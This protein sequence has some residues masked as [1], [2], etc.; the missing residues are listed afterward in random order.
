MDEVPLCLPELNIQGH[1]DGFIYS[2]TPIPKNWPKI[3]DLELLDDV[4]E[5]LQ[6]KPFKSIEILEIKS[7][8][9]GQF[10]S[11]TAPLEEHLDQATSYAA[12][13]EDRRKKL[14][15][16]YTG[17]EEFIA[18]EPDRHKEHLVRFRFATETNIPDWVKGKVF[19]GLLSDAILFNTQNPVDRSIFL[20]E[21]K[22]D[23]EIKEF[24]IKSDS[25]RLK[26]LREKCITINQTVEALNFLSKLSSNP[27]D[28]SK[29]KYLN[30]LPSLPEEAR[31]KSSKH[32]RWCDFKHICYK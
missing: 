16:R 4:Y 8:N 23:Q 2:Y 21:D 10:K 32:C 11:L 9:T 28:F 7:M 1:T 27:V 12:C 20:Y 19:K 26:V 17:W 22:N 24:V 6:N 13:A 18:S 3:L 31:G 25:Q 5:Y 14:H 15:Q 30:L 29:R